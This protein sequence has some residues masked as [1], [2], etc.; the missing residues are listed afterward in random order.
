MKE[1]KKRMKINDKVLNT[2]DIKEAEALLAAEEAQLALLEQQELE[3]K[4]AMFKENQLDT[5]NPWGY[6]NKGLAAKSAAMS[7]LSTK[8]GLYARIPITCK[9]H[10]CPYS[11]TCA[12]LEAG[13]EPYGEKCAIETELIDRA[14][15]GYKYD[16]GLDD[17]A[18]YTDLNIIKNIISCDVMMERAQALLSQEKTAISET[19]AG[20]NEKTGEDFYNKD[21]SKTLDLF[22]RHEKQ[23]NR[24]YDMMLAT[25]KAKAQAKQS[26]G[27]SVTD[28][29]MNA[30]NME[31]E[32]EEKP[33]YID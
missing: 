24:L 31:I 7:M 29:M 1:V 21:I 3:N 28:M 23:R 18:S 19:Y 33:D 25:R 10:G 9:G 12:L 17:N 8:S 5:S 32:Y 14:F 16:F 11:E 27:N 20:S 30:L 15:E 6:S 2:E 13:L 26:D 4:L 22:E